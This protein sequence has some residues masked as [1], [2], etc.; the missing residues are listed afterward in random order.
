MERR[1]GTLRAVRCEARAMRQLRCWRGKL[2][3]YYAAITGRKAWP[4]VRSVGSAP[5][6]VE[7]RAGCEVAKLHPD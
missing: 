7:D 4:T 2:A 5:V 3:L 1:L 6:S